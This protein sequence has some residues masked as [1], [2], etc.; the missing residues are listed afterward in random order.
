MSDLE[1]DFAA[2]ALA[3][4]T[5]DHRWAF[6]TGFTDALEGVDTTVPDRSGR[7][8]AGRVLPDAGRRRTDPEPPSAAVDDARSR[9]RGGD[10]D[11]QHR[12]RSARARPVCCSPGPA[13][14]TGPDRNEDQFAFWRDEREFRNVRLVERADADFAEMLAR[15]L[16]FSTWR[17]AQFDALAL[18]R[19]PGAVG[20]R[21]QGRQ[22]T[23]LSPRLRRPMG[24][25]ARGRHRRIAPPDAG[26]TG[27]RVAVG[28]RALPAASGRGCSVR[29]GRR[30]FDP[31]NRCRRR[32]RHRLRHRDSD[33]PNV[34]PSPGFAVVSV[35][36]AC[37]PK[38]SGTSSPRCRASPAP[39]RARRGDRGDRGSE[40]GRGR[41]GRRRAV[42]PIRNCPWSRWPTSGSC[43]PCRKTAGPSP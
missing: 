18:V 2:H 1:D 32:P 24:R 42:F 28:G 6:G 41:L 37:T 29:C 3:Q 27:R 30:R 7:R 5:E 40:P 26:R 19:R 23:D 14:P 8:R 11:R 22:G 39:I 10:G 21:G 43:G 20:D 38:L 36:M 31:T 25:P 4:D 15:L 34:G 33:R 13:R 12:A 16:I 9:A 17:L 35:E